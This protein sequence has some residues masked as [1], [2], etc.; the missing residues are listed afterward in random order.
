[1]SHANQTYHRTDVRS[2]PEIPT[3]FR[4]D[5]LAGCKALCRLVGGYAELT[6][7]WLDQWQVVGILQPS[8]SFG[9]GP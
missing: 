2:S 3:M 6:L 7:A 8:G 5:T 9:V 4:L 1:M